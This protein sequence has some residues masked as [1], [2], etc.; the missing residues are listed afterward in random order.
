MSQSHLTSLWNHEAFQ[1]ERDSNLNTLTNRI[2]R[3]F[4]LAVIAVAVGAAVF[5]LAA[6]DAGRGV[7]AFISVLIVACPCALAL[8]APF[9]LGTAQRLLARMQVFLK[10]AL[11]I[12]RLAQVEAIVF[13]K[14]GTLT[15]GSA[16]GVTFLPTIDEF[17]RA[18]DP[19]TGPKHPVPTASATHSVPPRKAGFTRL[20]GTRRIRWRRGL[21]KSLAAKQTPD[22]VDALVETPGCGL[23]GRVQGHE[24]RLGSRAWLASSGVATPESPQQEGS[25][26]LSGH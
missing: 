25:A 2:S 15:A 10:N 14:T 24:L 6:G 8:A 19:D 16:E 7:K 12:E 1:K 11:V 18:P 9:T 4:T 5:W 22:S 26:G 17:P 21:A 3:R 13:D 23:Q 20:P